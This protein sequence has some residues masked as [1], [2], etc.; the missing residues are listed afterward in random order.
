MMKECRSVAM[1]LSTVTLQP[2]G[3][4]EDSFQT[5]ETVL[6]GFTRKNI[7]LCSRE[8]GCKIVLLLQQFLQRKEEGHLPSV[9]CIRTFKATLELY[10]RQVQPVGSA[11]IIAAA[12]GIVKSAGCNPPLLAENGGHTNSWAHSLILRMRLVKGNGLRY[13]R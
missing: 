12:K 10:K 6:S 3:N 9:K 2:L 4:L 5:L 8:N 1:L 7:F 13:K 11:V